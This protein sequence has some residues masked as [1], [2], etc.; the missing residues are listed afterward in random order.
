M[1]ILILI[2]STS[3]MTLIMQMIKDSVVASIKESREKL[4]KLK[5]HED[6]IFFKIG[7]Y[8]NY[9]SLEEKLF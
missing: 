2:D 6:I 7:G 9:F 5:I 4:R 3:S 1:K 8:R